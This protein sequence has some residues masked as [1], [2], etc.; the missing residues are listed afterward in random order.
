MEQLQQRA[1]AE[2]TSSA[3]EPDLEVRW[4]SRWENK[5]AIDGEGGTTGVAQWLSP[6]PPAGSRERATAKGRVEGFHATACAQTS[7]WDTVRARVGDIA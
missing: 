3:A 4:R 7:R 6:A 5:W 2:Q 1:A